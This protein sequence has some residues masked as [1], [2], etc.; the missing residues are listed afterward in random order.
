MTLEEKRQLHIEISQMLSDAGINQST[1]KEMIEKQLSAKIDRAID[2]FFNSK[3][4]ID[5]YNEKLEKWINK[6]TSERYLMDMIVKILQKKIIHI[7]LKDT[8]IEKE[9][10]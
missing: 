9:K 4:N 3:E 5:K 2:N 10:K 1:L 6:Y 7:E 8:E